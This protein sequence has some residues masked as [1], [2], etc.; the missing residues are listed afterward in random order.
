MM[1]SLAG[2]SRTMPTDPRNRG[3]YL[4]EAAIGAVVLLILFVPPGQDR[5]LWL[6]LI[7][8]L[9]TTARALLFRRDLQRY[10][11]HAFEPERGG[12]RG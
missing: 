7:V 6:W 9:G 3:R 1:S 4:N 5:P 12:P 2:M 10:R 11:R 8:A